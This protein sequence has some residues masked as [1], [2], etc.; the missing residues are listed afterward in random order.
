MPEKCRYKSDENFI[1]M[2]NAINKFVLQQTGV[3]IIFKF[4]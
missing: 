1:S 3:K 2:F 4:L